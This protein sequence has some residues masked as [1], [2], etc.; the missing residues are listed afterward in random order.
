MTCQCSFTYDSKDQ[1][2]RLM[3]E[4][5]GPPYLAQAMSWMTEPNSRKVTLKKR[6]TAFQ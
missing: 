3:A 2:T 5:G 6:E 4:F 1:F